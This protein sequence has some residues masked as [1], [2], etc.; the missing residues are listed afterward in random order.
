MTLVPEDSITYAALARL[1]LK[2]K[3]LELPNML[4]I[5]ARKPR[6]G[7]ELQYM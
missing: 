7:A 1:H 2:Y 3:D 6:H 5:I 4:E